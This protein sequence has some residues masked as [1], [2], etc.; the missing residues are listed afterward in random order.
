MLNIVKKISKLTNIHK[1]N[2]KDIFVYRNNCLRI[3]KVIP[4]ES[5]DLIVTDPP[6]LIQKTG[7]TSTFK[8]GYLDN[9]LGVEGK[10]FKHNDI[11]VS[12]YAPL[13]YKVLKNGSHCYVMTN[14]KNLRKILNTFCDC[15]FRFSMILC[16]NKK[17]KMYC[18]MYMKQC[19]YILLFSKAGKGETKLV[20]DKSVS[21]LISIS[22]IANKKHNHPTEKPVDLMK[23]FVEQ[24]SKEGDIVLDPFVGVG[25]TAIACKETNR[26]FIGC[27][28]D[29]SYFKTTIKRLKENRVRRLF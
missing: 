22:N 28:L 10:L 4:K 27:E 18:G 29:K 16:W 7:S 6:Y 17:N 5:I 12:E 11:D 25:A 15:G 21:N 19:E 24:S 9:N 23:V 20:N 1:K 13:F 2:I 3:L 8:G 14:D 26:K